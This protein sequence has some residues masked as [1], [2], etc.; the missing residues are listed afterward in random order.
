MLISICVQSAKYKQ[1]IF[2]FVFYSKIRFQHFSHL[3]STEEDGKK[4]KK[5]KKDTTEAEE[6][7][8]EVIDNQ[9]EEG[10]GMLDWFLSIINKIQYKLKYR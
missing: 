10:K 9:E 4:K 3:F 1:D 2:L 7:G 5:G 8:F 6:A